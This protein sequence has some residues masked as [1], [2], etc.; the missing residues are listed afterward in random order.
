[1]LTAN[2]QEQVE[3][4]YYMKVNNVTFDLM[5]SSPKLWYLEEVRSRGHPFNR[6]E[7]WKKELFQ[8]EQDH[9]LDWA[10][11]F[12]SPYSTMRGTKMQSFAFKLVYRIIPCNEYL[13]KI[14][15][16]DNPTCAFC[17][18]SDSIV[19]FFYECTSV[20]AL[21]SA[22]ISWWEDYLDLTLSNLVVAEILFCIHRQVRQQKL[23]NWILLC[24]IFHTKEKAFLQGRGVSP[25]ASGIVKNQAPQRK[26]GV[27]LGEYSEE[28]QMLGKSR[29]LGKP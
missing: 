20:T 19:H 21:W 18:S 27:H 10:V 24:K 17:E 1:M 25:G 5:T 4:G 28:I 22:L 7:G 2:F 13:H 6:E 9:K 29:P 23:I 14:R 16:K 3:M 11:I 8:E 26:K 12:A 15:I